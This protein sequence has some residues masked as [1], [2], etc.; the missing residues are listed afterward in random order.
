M[1]NWIAETAAD[2]GTDVHRLIEEKIVDGK[3]PDFGSMVGF[4]VERI[5]DVYK[6]IWAWLE[7]N[8]AVA[9]AMEYPV[10]SNVIQ[11]A[12]RIDFLGIDKNG[13]YHIVDFKTSKRL[14]KKSWISGYFAQGAAY[15]FCL[16]ERTGIEVEKIS[17]VVGVDHEP[18]AQEFTERA[19]DWMP[20]F[21]ECRSKYLMDADASALS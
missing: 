13:K 17:I 2:R 19:S 6:L 5:G 9:K 12:G 4:D 20:L 14:K 16:E 21:L 10:W 1:A 7:E 3:E 18:D 8:M 15:A 11:T